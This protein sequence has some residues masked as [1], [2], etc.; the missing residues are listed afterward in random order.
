MQTHTK[1]IFF[2][3]LLQNYRNDFNDFIWQ[4]KE[5][6]KDQRQITILTILTIFGNHGF[7]L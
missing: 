4:T 7:F 6:S 1:K 3:L 5:F 2:L